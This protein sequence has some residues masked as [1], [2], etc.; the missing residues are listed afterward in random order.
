MTDPRV[1]G[2]VLAAGRSSRLGRPK[3]LL[4]LD[5]LPLVAHAVAAANGSVL[6]PVIVVLGNA[7]A[8]IAAVIPAGRHEVV[9]NPRFADGQATSM[10]AGLAAIPP[11]AAAVLFLLGDQPAVTPAHI[12]ALVDRFRA[13]GAPVVQARFG[14]EPGNPVLVSRALFPELAAVSGD[15]GA[16][17]V[18]RA[19][20]D[21]IA[22]VDFDGPVPRDVDTGED[23]E[24]LLRE[25]GR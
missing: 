17:S 10:Q 19:H 9:T 13:T 16:R 12:D 2:I 20:R 22:W 11:D 25:W 15:E 14:G 23:Y 7:A 18:V 4:D 24:A 1:A 6:D 8:E 3:Q 5:G 21:A